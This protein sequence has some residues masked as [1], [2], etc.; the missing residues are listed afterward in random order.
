VCS[1]STDYVDV[2]SLTPR[3]RSRVPGV[4]TADLIAR[5]DDM[6]A[7]LLGRYCD[8][9]LPG[10]QLSEERSSVMRVVFISNAAGIKTGFRAKYEFVDKKPV[11]KR[12]RTPHSLLVTA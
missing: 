8:R 5:L 3:R 11:A 2:F 9:V 1:C 7:V 10:P 4:D 12:R 6:E